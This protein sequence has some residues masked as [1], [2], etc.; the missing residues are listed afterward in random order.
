[1]DRTGLQAPAPEGLGGDGHSA[2]DGLAAISEMLVGLLGKQSKPDVLPR[3]SLGIEWSVDE[4]GVAVKSLLAGSP[5]AASELKVGDRI[6][7]FQ[8]KAVKSSADILRLAGKITAGQAVKLKV[9]R[10]EQ[11]QEITLK[12]G[13]GF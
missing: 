5:A 3:G 13:E 10:G 1:M 9:V 12:A 11:T 8:D 7:H 2:M 6:S 4:A